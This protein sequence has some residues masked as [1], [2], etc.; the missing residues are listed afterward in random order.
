MDDPRFSQENVEKAMEISQDITSSDQQAAMGL[1]NE[2]MEQPSSLFTALQLVRTTNSFY[3]SFMSSSLI[4]NKISSF[5]GQMEPDQRNEYRESLSTLIATVPDINN[6]ISYNLI[7]ALCYIALSD[8]PV[9]FQNFSNI[10]FPSNESGTIAVSLRILSSFMEEIDTSNLITDLRRNNLRQL[11]STQQHDKIME[12]ISTFINAPELA[13]DILLICNYM[14]RWGS[15]ED[16]INFDLFQKLSLQFL[17]DEHACEKAVQCLTSIFISRTDSAIAFRT[18]SPFLADALAKGIFPN[19]KPVT[20]NPHVM[21]FLLRFLLEYSSIFELVL[22]YDQAKNDETASTFIDENVV[23]LVET[24]NQKGISQATL[25]EDLLQLYQIIL[26]I[27]PNQIIEEV[28]TYF[29]QL[30]DNN[31]RRVCYEQNHNMTVN[32]ASSFYLPFLDEIRRSLFNSLSSSIDKDGICLFQTRTTIGTL[33]MINQNAF[34]DFLKVQPPSPQLC[35][36]IGTIEFALDNNSKLENVLMIIIELLQHA[37]VD[38]SP[39]Y[40]SALLFGMSHSTRCYQSNDQLFS[41]FIEF[42]LSSMIGND[43]LVSNAATQA[44]Y[45]IVQRKAGLFK[46][47]CRYYAEL[48]ISHSEAYLQNLEPQAAIRIFKVCTWL[49]CYNK[50]NSSSSGMEVIEVLRSLT[51]TLISS[52]ANNN[53]NENLLDENGC[54]ELYV[55]LFNP[56]V[57]VLNKPDQFPQETVETALDII[58]EC[59]LGSPSLAPAIFSFLWPPLFNL[60]ANMIPNVNFQNNILSYVL[61]AMSS[62]QVNM[63]FSQTSVQVNEIFNL[64]TQRQKIEES[65]FEYFTVIRDIFNE[66]DS[67]YPIIHQQLV[68]PSL[69]SNEPLPGSMFLMIGQFTPDVV[70]IEWLTMAAIQALN[71]LRPEVGEDALGAL[72]SMIHKLSQDNFIKFLNNVAPQLISTV[73][74]AIVDLMHKPLFIKLIDFLRFI[75]MSSDLERSGNPANSN[76]QTMIRNVI[77]SALKNFALEPN[78]GFFENFADYLLS[79]QRQFFK[80]KA[81]F[82]NLLVVLRKASPSDAEL[83]KIEPAQ[84]NSMFS[85]MFDSFFKNL[86]PIFEIHTIDEGPLLRSKQ[87]VSRL[88]KRKNPTQPGQLFIFQPRLLPVEHFQ[89]Q[90]AAPTSEQHP[91]QPN[92]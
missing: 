37:N 53:N 91:Q 80:F 29:W 65:F 76:M 92:Q 6:Q 58:R 35:H 16:I 60:A 38:Q 51:T 40:L 50:R 36:A 3:C 31:L 59:C 1:L 61:N 62:M 68:T 5:W 41:Q 27:P 55:K 71:E 34:F 89:Q 72:Q 30:W 32:A 47:E 11:I 78:P 83:F 48:L 86:I 42:I 49:I 9:D 56:I 14:L 10:I 64:M 17:S 82:G 81:A 45:Y 46:G 75:I 39:E 87:V 90:E 43:K 2:W 19:Q 8:W 69:S 57:A 88:K 73:I 28:Q 24:M 74:G 44:L 66:L 22:I 63:S 52:D 25:R 33:F 85:V 21:I 84:Q 79:V 15:V 77:V 7:R 13:N 23:L 20:S 26:S 4:K 54:H 12:M 67:M 70:D 18:F